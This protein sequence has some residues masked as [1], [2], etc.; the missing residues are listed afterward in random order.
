MT[1][2]AHEESGKRLFRFFVPYVDNFGEAIPEERR[3][4]FIDVVETESCKLNGGYTAFDA[5][6]GYMSDRVDIIKEDVT[7]IETYGEN[8]IPPERM[9]HCSRYM[10][11][12][13][14][15]VTSV[16]NYDFMDYKGGP[17]GDITMYKLPRPK[18][19]SVD[20]PA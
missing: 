14:L 13:S 4:D 2:S 20:L 6:G 7:I 10:A 11:Q 12:E 18:N 16:G 15:I 17:A 19:V 3:R 9:A 8:P 1:E 5:R